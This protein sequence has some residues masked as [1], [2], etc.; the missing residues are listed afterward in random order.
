MPINF[1]SKTELWMWDYEG[2]VPFYVVCANLKRTNAFQK[3]KSDQIIYFDWLRHKHWNIGELFV[4]IF[5]SCGIMK[6]NYMYTEYILAF[7]PIH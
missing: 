6:L 7:S 4:H 2:S 3:G 5:T 1:R